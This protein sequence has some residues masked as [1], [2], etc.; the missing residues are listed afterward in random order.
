MSISSTKTAPHYVWGDRCDGWRLLD[1]ADLS[2]IEERMPPGTAELRHVH[3]RANQLF[4][5]LEGRLSLSLADG[6]LELGP[7]DAL[8]IRPGT[9]HQARNDGDDP[10]RFLVISAPTTAGDRQ[11]V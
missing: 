6:P 5:V 2:V 1:G 3:D 4:Y 8:N 10:V 9:E 11:T 7:G